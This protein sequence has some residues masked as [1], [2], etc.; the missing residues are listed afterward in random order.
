MKL[1][2]DRQ[3]DNARDF[4]DAVLLSG[5]EGCIFRGVNDANY[6][7]TPKIARP[8]ILKKIR[9]KIK[10]SSVPKYHGIPGNDELHAI[11]FY[12]NH[13]IRTFYNNYIMANLPPIN[14]DA[15]AHESLLSLTGSRQGELP[16]SVRYTGNIN[17]HYWPVL[18]RMQHL[19]VET[20]LLDWSYNPAVA[21]F[22]ATSLNVG[23]NNE[24]ADL[25]AVWQVNTRF[26]RKLG[27]F[28]KVYPYN[29]I[30]ELMARSKD[31]S[32]IPNDSLRINKICVYHPP[33]SNNENIDAQKGVFTLTSMFSFD[34]DSKPTSCLDGAERFDLIKVL[35]KSVHCLSERQTE[36]V[37]PFL[38]EYP[39]V[40]CHK[41]S[42]EFAPEVRNNLKKLGFAGF[43]L[44][45]EGVS[46]RNLMQDEIENWLNSRVFFEID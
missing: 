15:S 18:S 33:P 3:Y 21:A 20:R 19:G 16:Y 41:L 42:S 7:L 44:L 24:Q 17:P 46:V 28:S 10:S 14:L 22:F 25:I 37:A 4:I 8:K 35:Q 43:S 38:T 6:D 31:N 32:N 40:V 12:E 9:E 1:V 27:A 5:D 36:R 23:H 13:L 45:R 2:E 11:I 34:T 39:P 26:I 29:E 30:Q